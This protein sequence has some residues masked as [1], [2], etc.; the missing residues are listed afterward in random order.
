[1]EGGSGDTDLPMP[2]RSPVVLIVA[3]GRGN[4]FD[5]NAYHG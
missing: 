3:R 2:A 4:D 1:M 5:A